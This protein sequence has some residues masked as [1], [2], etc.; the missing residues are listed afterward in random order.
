MTDTARRQ[1]RRLRRRLGGRGLLAILGS[2]LLL[3][4]AVGIV[5]AV[6]DEQFQLEGNT[7]VDASPPDT[8]PNGDPNPF[9]NTDF[10]W[11]SLF[12][13]ASDTLTGPGNRP[14]EVSPLPN[15]NF[16][17]AEFIEDWSLV[18]GVYQTS[19]PTT[20]TQSKDI[21]NVSAWRCKA[22]NQV[23][24]KGDITNAYAAVWDDGTKR[25]LYFGLE[26]DQD[27]GS[28]NV[29]IW[30]LQ[31]A[32]SCPG[33]GTGN[34]NPFSGTHLPGDIFM[35]SEFTNGGGVSTIRGY[36]WKADIN[37]K[38]AGNQPGLDPNPF[39]VSGD[40]TV[41]AG[42]PGFDDRM[43]ATSNRVAIE[44]AWTHWSFENGVNN[45]MRA[46]TFVEGGISLLEFDQFQN[47]CFSRFLMNTRSSQELTATLYDYALGDINT[48]NANV[49]IATSA[50][51]VVGNPHTFTITANALGGVT[52]ASIAISPTLSPAVVAPATTSNT[53]ASPTYSNGNKTATCTVTISSPN[54]GTYTANATATFN[55]GDSTPLV[56]STSGNSGPGGSGPATKTFVTARIS[57]ATAGTN[58]LGAPH[59]FT[60][61]VEQNNGSGW[62][63]APNINVLAAST[64]VGGI[65]AGG[66]CDNTGVNGTSG[67]TDSSGQCTIIVDSD[68]NTG[69]ATVNAS[70]TVPVS[71]TV[72]SASVSV[73]TNGSGAHT[74]SNTKTWVTADIQIQTA[75]TNKVGEAHTFT[76]TVR[77]DSGAGL[78]AAQ[79]VTVTPSIS[80]AGSITGGTCVAS[81][82]TKT[83]SSGQC[84]IVVSSS[85]AGTATVNA[86]AAVVIAGTA[87]SATVNVATNGSGAGPTIS[88]T[89]TWVDARISI[90]TAGTNQLG[91]AHTFTVTVQKNSGSG[92]V[93]AQGVNVLASETGV[94]AI[95][96]GTCDNSGGDTDASGQ[97]T[98]VVDSDTLT[99]TSTV[100]ASATVT[101]A[102]TAGSANVA[103]ATNGYG[104][105]SISNTKTWVDADI[106][107][108][109]SATNNITEAH[110][111][112]VTIR[113]DSGS[114]MAPAEG[115]NVLASAV[116]GGVGSI[117][118]GTCDNTGGDTN[119][120]GQCT[121]VVQSAVAGSLT[122]NASATVR[123]NGT[124]G[125]AD[126]SVSTT[127]HGAYSI[128]N[129][130]TWVDGTLR[131]LK[132]DGDGNL[133]GGA[134]F[135]VCRTH[136][137]NSDT[138]AF[139]NTADVCYSPDDTPADQVL[140]DVDGTDGPAG[141]GLDQDGTGGEFQLDNLVLGRYTIEESKAPAGY[142]RDES[143]ETVEL[144]IANRSNADGG[145]GDIV[146][147]FVNL[148]A[149]RLIVLTC[150]DITNEL[151]ASLVDFDGNLVTLADQK[152]TIA[153]L[154]GYLVAKGVTEGDICGADVDGN[155]NV[156]GI[157]GA[158]YGDLDDGT[159]SPKVM[160]PS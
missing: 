28:N 157:G 135:K 105:N 153:N 158:S 109:A 143:V 37:A 137:F 55:Y 12:T 7:A 129:V 106:T 124:A 54:P 40:C 85:S 9:A 4:G 64:G 98:I 16:K 91:D 21:D 33:G 78:V 69:T 119:S 32:V 57:I 90:G 50:T 42:Q 94:G 81:G 2:A 145:T 84:T 89:K 101:V 49:S 45:G 118:G 87:G 56:R 140:D 99:G 146:P 136:T 10:D 75:G 123:V 34:G 111:F 126:V 76:V 159:Y 156:D 41:S 144:T 3:A 125:F 97:C 30:L 58:V 70:A 113:K 44:P 122:V 115:V 132:H 141:A 51:N 128:S 92:F 36:E 11:E 72:G 77:K 23:T 14:V 152:T 66:T 147:V 61:T 103:V 110:T 67:D 160:I 31:S 107:I 59:T 53:C 43:C 5:L 134:E 139:D 73:A 112:T 133:L 148:K 47:K 116:A 88:N 127:G 138:L 155:P 151:I 74:V 27:S 149:F 150:D 52:P 65:V 22:A 26:K 130:K 62:V 39:L 95:T 131:W 25:I 114:G 154:P 35:V 120:S 79:N 96:G 142:H 8:L 46:A 80:G 18:D 108:S 48:C 68:V 104:Q 38:Q 117:T 93:A 86:S 63:A 6:H 83:D 13:D 1:V 100:Q 102:G 17:D 20:F 19:D 29:G 71:G 121:I 15:A 82:A 60:V 24:N